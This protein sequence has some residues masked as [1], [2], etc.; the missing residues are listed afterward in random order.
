MCLGIPGRVMEVFDT[1][2]MSATVDV[3][4]VPRR[5][6]LGLLPA[7]EQVGPGDLVLVHMGYAV[8]RM[9][10]AEAA[11]ATELF[12]GFG[13]ALGDVRDDLPAELPR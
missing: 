7:D 3:N 12:E 9:T 8:S 13:D 5:L 2:P 1:T 6:S 4:G 10:E 11:E